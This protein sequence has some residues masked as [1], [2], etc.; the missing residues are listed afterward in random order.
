MRTPA[1]PR[2]EERT[3]DSLDL[4]VGVEYGEVGGRQRLGGEHL[5]DGLAVVSGP[6]QEDDGADGDLV[7]LA[8]SNHLRQFGECEYVGVNLPV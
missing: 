7:T 5:P 4:A 1:A 8:R 2:L 3:S 6:A